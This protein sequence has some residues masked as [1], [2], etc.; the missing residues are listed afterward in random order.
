MARANVFD[1]CRSISKESITDDVDKATGSVSQASDLN[2]DLEA[3]DDLEPQLKGDEGEKPDADDVDASVTNTPTMEP[4]MT[5]GGGDGTAHVVDVKE[6]KASDSV[7]NHVTAVDQ[8]ALGDVANAHQKVNANDGNVATTTSVEEHKDDSLE[9]IET[10][11]VESVPEADEMVMDIDE[12]TEALTADGLTSATD[13]AGAIVDE[14]S[15]DLG[16]IEN[17]KASVER[18]LGVLSGMKDNGLELS[19]EMAE[20]MRIG[21]ESISDEFFVGTV[22]SIEEIADDGADAS[23]RD[24]TSSKL[25]ATLKKLVEAAK[26]AMFRILNALVDYWQSMRQDTTKLKERLKQLRSKVGILDGGST[27]KIGGLQRLSIAGNFV[28]DSPEA[29]KSVEKVV[30]TLVINWPSKMAEVLKKFEA[31]NS[32]L[33]GMKEATYSQLL[34]AV[35]DLL[36]SGFRDFKSVSPNQK[37]KVPSGL[38]NSTDVYMSAVLPGNRAV[39]VGV[40]TKGEVQGHPTPGRDVTIN[41]SVIPGGES[42]SGNDQVKVMSGGEA[43]SVIR[44]LEQL[45][46][47]ID[48]ATEGRGR[49][50]E[51]AD[52]V[53]RSGGQA[54]FR[55]MLNGDENTILAAYLAMHTATVTAKTNHLFTGYVLNLIKASIAVIE[56]MVKHE[57]GDAIEAQ[58]A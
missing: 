54:M 43:V 3:K 36:A 12:A 1:L 57:Q 18:Y 46:S 24:T 56:A 14:I 34:D 48:A 26:N 32:Y 15:S 51:L 23:A 8:T 33:F 4:G 39:Y 44:A 5:T 27:I 45:V 50:K 28:G 25:G 58:A 30:D 47:K 41:F 11:E 13:A 53:Q 9:T 31:N 38:L 42:Y 10:G 19:N 37:D 20:V 16:D 21:L 55:G 6:V 40:N 7:A 49:L 17:A 22:V 29:I 35:N 52:N 2:V